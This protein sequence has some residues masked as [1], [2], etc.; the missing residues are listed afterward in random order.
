ME[1]KREQEYATFGRQ[2]GYVIGANIV[3]VLLV[4]IQ[5]PILTR[6]LGAHLYGTWSLVNVSIYLLFPFAMLGLSTAIVRFLAAEKD[7]GRIREDFFSAGSI[8]GITGVILSLLLFSLSHIIGVHILK[9]ADL[10][11]YIKLASVLILFNAMYQFLRNF[12]R[13]QR[14]IGLYT[15]IALMYDISQVGLIILFILLGYKLSG[16]IT[17]LIINGLLFNLITLFIILKQI[18]F[19]FP[20]FSRMKSYLRW[21][22]PLTPN[23]AIMWIINTS[24]RYMVSYF[25]GVA[26]A[27]IY[28]AAYSIGYYASFALMPLG[29]VMYPNVVKTYEE[30]NRDMTRNY[31]KYSIK[32]LM[33]VAIPSAFGLSILAKPLL[34]ILTTPEFVP[35]SNIVP[36]VAF[37]AV[38][39]CVYQI[40]VT[41]INL[42]GKNELVAILL[43][44][45]AGLNILLNIVLIPRMGIMGAA[46]AT[47]VA[48]LVLGM[49]TLI[50]SSRYFKFDIDIL[51]IA[52]SFFASAV[53][54]FCIWLISPNSIA[55]VVISIFAGAVIYFAVLLLIRTLS[56]EELAFFINLLKHKGKI[57]LVR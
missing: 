53:M 5:L 30:G 12:F 17:A 41:V 4:F 29:T 35:G 13:V 1:Q 33:M 14:R 2:V 38:L 49:L 19:Q 3:T 15:I 43:G 28:N 54:A 42:A 34:Q 11:F 40:H 21:G 56:K 32:Y 37:G 46:L 44:T 25:L 6:A 45:A 55:A 18:G 51:S 10:A 57:Q 24:D 23:E 47:L 50:V 48:Y 31:L 27:G 36:F 7:V 8:V 52:K 9:D 39:R 22:L 26:A 16:A 20:K